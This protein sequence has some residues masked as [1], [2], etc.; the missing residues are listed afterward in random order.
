MRP[1]ER[2]ATPTM[3]RRAV[4]FIDYR[5]ARE[6]LIGRL[7]PYCSYCEISHP[8][9]AVEHIQPKSR[10]PRLWTRWSNFLLACWSCNSVKGKKRVRIHA[11]VWPDRDNTHRAFS[12]DPHGSVA[13][14]AGLSR[15]QHALAVATMNLVGLDRT[16]AT[17]PRASDS[18]RRWM[19]RRDTAAVAARV[20]QLLSR[21]RTQ[22][23][24]ELAAMTARAQ[25]CWSIWMRQ[26]SGDPD[27]LSRLIDVFPGT[28]KNCWRPGGATRQRPRGKL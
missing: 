2:G 20:H 7:G 9:L 21:Q 27:M 12:Y 15:K 6:Y 11:F 8:S 26:F 24:K 22:E 25:G 14:G 17:S 10:H 5:S 13:I 16:P 1:V 4:R 18:D 3:G 19:I 28:A 23:M